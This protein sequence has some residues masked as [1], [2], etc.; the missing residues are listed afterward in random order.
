M[1]VPLSPESQVCVFPHSTITN[2]LTNSVLQSAPLQASLPIDFL[3]VGGGIA[4]LA[5]AIALRRVGHRAV[6]LERD[7][8]F[9]SVCILL[10]CYT[11]VLTMF[12]KEKSSG[13]CR[14]APNLS[15]VSAVFH[16]YLSYP[17]L[18]IN[19]CHR[20]YFIGAWKRNSVKL[21]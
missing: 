21:P 6:V 14:L 17:I 12:L 9:A 16:T 18:K 11:P 2:S 19:H 3:I 5:C 7:G 4:G 10:Q 13:G 8:G 15:K 1:T 20:Y